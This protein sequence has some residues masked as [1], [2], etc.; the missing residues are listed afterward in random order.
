MMGLLKEEGKVV[1]DGHR[2]ATAEKEEVNAGRCMTVGVRRKNG[3]GEK[4]GRRTGGPMPGSFCYLAKS[5]AAD[6]ADYNG[7]H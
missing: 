3:K 2:T 5:G 6:T 7:V 1:D 4:V